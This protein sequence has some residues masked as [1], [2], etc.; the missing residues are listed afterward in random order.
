MN[1]RAPVLEVDRL[2]VA[3]DG[4]HA[5]DDLS[6]AVGA[7]ETLAIAGESGS[8]KS[9]T[10][11]AVMGL[12]PREAKVSARSIRLAGREIA[13]LPDHEMRRLRGS[14]IGLIFQE[15]MTALNPVM[16]IGEQI[17]ETV[18][19]HLGLPKRA[20]WRRAVELLDLLRVR[21]PQLLAREYPH[22]LSGG[23]RQRVVIAIAIAANP[24]LVIADEATTALDVTI[25]AEVLELL[26]RLRRE[27]EL[28]LILITHDL[29]IVGQWADRV[30]VMYAGRQVEQGEP[31]ALFSNP[32]HPYTAGLVG[33]APPRGEISG[34]GALGYRQ[35]ALKEIPGS[36]AGAAREAGCR[37]APRCARAI[38]SCRVAPPPALVPVAPG[39]LAAC[40]VVNA[41][42]AA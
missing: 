8:G 22:R 40:P 3:F 31:R 37:F 41:S 30:V 29:G 18:R 24:K 13:G 39:R 6:F 27:L 11:L 23:M 15:P 5:V 33:A 42:V 36:I 19:I 12:A 9:M 25:Q 35:A 17:A 20:A 28:G 10:A 1:G 21:D 32:R 38:A 34:D 16:T 7:G 2:T 14:E 4:F 26:D